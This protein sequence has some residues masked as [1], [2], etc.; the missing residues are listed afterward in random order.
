MVRRASH[1]PDV[2]AGRPGPRPS[3]W[4]RSSPA[5][6]TASSTSCSV[7]QEGHRHDRRPDHEPGHRRR[8][9]HR[10]PP[11]PF[12]VR[13]CRPRRSTRSARASCRSTPRTTRPACRA[14]AQAPAAAAGV[15]ARRPDRL[16][17]RQAGDSAGTTLTDS[18]RSSSSTT[19]PIVVHRD[20]QRPDPADHPDPDRAAGLRQPGQRREDRLRRHRDRAGRLP[21]RRPPTQVAAAA[22]DHRGARQAVDR[23]ERH[24]RRRPAHPAEDGRRRPGRVRLR[25]PRDP[26]G[27]VSVVGVGRFAGEI[28]SAQGGGSYTTKDK[29]ADL[30]N[31]DRGAEHRAVRLQ[32]DP[33]AA[34]GRR[35][36]RRGAVGGRPAPGRA[37]CAAG[38]TPARPTSPGCCRSPTSRARC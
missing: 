23:A 15:Q 1:R 33:A 31:V 27:P 2:A 36:R 26:N 5:T 16:L 8:P 35:T 24:G 7:P 13:R 10:S 17:R 21:R 25:R 9:A 19:V 6:R 30:L 37:G 12:G 20:G 28:A 34:A 38:P 29:I 22:V 32:P 11:P 3:R 18:I 14:D 4:R